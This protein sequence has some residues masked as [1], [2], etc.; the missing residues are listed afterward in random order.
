MHTY[1]KFQESQSETEALRTELTTARQEKANY[2]AKVTELR[3]T[4]KASVH[5]HKVLIKSVL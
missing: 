4:L 5:H 3:T 1:F 2:Q